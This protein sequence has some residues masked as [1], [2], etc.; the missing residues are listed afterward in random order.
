M[1][2]LW[3]GLLLLAIASAPV[4]AAGPQLF[5][6]DS[7]AAIQQKYAGRPFILSMW[8]AD[9]CSHC[10]TE[11]TMLGKVAAELNAHGKAAQGAANPPEKLPLVLV[12]TDTPG[13][14][15]PIRQTLKRLGLARMDSWVFDD[16]IPERLRHVI[17][18]SWYGELPRTYL[19]D[20]QHQRITVVG[21]MSEHKL[22]AWLKQQA[23]AF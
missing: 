9:G 18:P 5:K 22:K 17:D 15:G 2:P 4:Q 6:P 8:S 21:V 16:G 12:A 10:I 20:A 23:I 3:K 1:N 11:L 7:L 14:S 13:F 19:Y